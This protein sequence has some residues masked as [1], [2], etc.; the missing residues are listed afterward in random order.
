MR[1]ALAVVTLPVLWPV[2]VVRWATYDHE[3]ADGWPALV[4]VPEWLP[5]P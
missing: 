4:H 5:L 2:H 3:D 1:A